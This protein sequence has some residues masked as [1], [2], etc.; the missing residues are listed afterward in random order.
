MIDWDKYFDK[1][2][3]GIK[4]YVIVTQKKTR[5]FLQDR[6]E[7]EFSIQYEAILC[8]YLFMEYNIR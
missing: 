6:N 5:D 7:I 2:Y 4:F 1:F 3:C 8:F